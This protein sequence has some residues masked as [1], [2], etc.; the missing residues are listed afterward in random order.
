MEWKGQSP[1]HFFFCLN[2]VYHLTD[3][4]YSCI[5]I[6]YKFIGLFIEISYKSDKIFYWDIISILV[7]KWG[8]LTFNLGQLSM[9]AIFWSLKLPLDEVT[10]LSKMSLSE[11][12]QCSG[13]HVIVANWTI[14]AQ[15][16][17]KM[18]SFFF[19]PSYFFQSTQPL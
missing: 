11:Y 17:V 14:Y 5:D 6:I 18:F 10:E 4:Q 16:L 1:G 7:L 12:F 13:Q 19:F 8:G 9:K 15:I 3:S 2:K